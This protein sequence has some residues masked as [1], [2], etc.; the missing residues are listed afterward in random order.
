M[1]FFLQASL[2]YLGDVGGGEFK[3]KG[4]VIFLM[5]RKKLL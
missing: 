1:I 5:V 3:K 4:A 2:F